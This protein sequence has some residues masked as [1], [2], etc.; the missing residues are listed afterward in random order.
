MPKPGV[1]VDHA[2]TLRE[3]RRVEYPDPVEAVRVQG[4]PR[5]PPPLTFSV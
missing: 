1:N 2:A 3:A 4:R 5:Q